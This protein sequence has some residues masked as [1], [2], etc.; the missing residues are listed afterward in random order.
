MKTLISAVLVGV[1]AQPVVGCDLCAIYSASQAQGGTGRG[2]FGGVA[3]QFTKIGTVQDSGHEISSEGQYI[4]SS[5]SQV[6]TG[7]NFNDRFSIQLNLPV[8]YRAY[9]S[10]T[11]RGTVSGIGDLSLTGSFKVYEK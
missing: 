2:F 1:V 9:G 11:Q 6:L 10:D 3:E 4:H 5:V 8:I 7:Y